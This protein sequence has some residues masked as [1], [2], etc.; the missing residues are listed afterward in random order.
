MKV[1][2]AHP[3]SSYERGTNENTNG[4]IREFLPKGRS[5]NEK[6]KEMLK[7]QEALNGR[8]RKILGYRS[9]EEYHFDD[10]IA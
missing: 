3:Y 4:L 10:T 1:Y 8:C 5:I 2:F 9:S 6:E 7:I